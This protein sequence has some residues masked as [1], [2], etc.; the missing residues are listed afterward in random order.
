MIGVKVLSAISSGRE[1]R[2]FSHSAKRCFTILIR[3]LG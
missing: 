1:D 3:I 2:E